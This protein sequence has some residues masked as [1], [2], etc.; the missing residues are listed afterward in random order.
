MDLLEQEAKE[1]L[2]I[3]IMELIIFY[4]HVLEEAEAEEVQEGHYQEAEEAG[5]MDQV[6]S[7]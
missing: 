7:W 3:F 2:Y 4:W 1:V 6:G 5:A